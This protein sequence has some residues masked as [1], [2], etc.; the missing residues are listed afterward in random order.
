MHAMRHICA[1]IWHSSDS[2]C[3]IGPSSGRSGNSVWSVEIP[4]AWGGPVYEYF[5]RDLSQLST[6]LWGPTSREKQALYFIKSF[7]PDKVNSSATLEGYYTH[8]PYDMSNG[9]VS[10]GDIVRY[11]P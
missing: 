4:A 6:N 11:G 3:G 10:Q 9:V 5:E 1:W 7:G 8:I 2:I